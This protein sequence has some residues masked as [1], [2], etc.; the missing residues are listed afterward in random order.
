MNSKNKSLRR[1]LST[2]VKACKIFSNE[3]NPLSVCPFITPWWKCDFLE[4][5]EDFQYQ[6]AYRIWFTLSVVLSVMLQKYIFQ[7]MKCFIIFLS[8]FFI[9]DICSFKLLVGISIHFFILRYLAIH[10]STTKNYIDL[11]CVF[12]SAMLVLSG[13]K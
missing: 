10:K 2:P 6:W 5:F 13:K 8:I 4:C 12:L 11:I 1:W 9:Y 7:N 3:A